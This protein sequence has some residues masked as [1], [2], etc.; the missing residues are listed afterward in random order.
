MDQTMTQPVAV[1]T[2]AASGIGL[3]VTQRLARTHRVALLDINGEA[4]LQAAEQLGSTA[5]ALRCDISD[6][7]SVTAAVQAVFEQFGA[8]DVA[9][10]NAGIGPVGAIR[11][12][13]PAVLAT[14]LDVNLTGNWRFIRACLPHLIGSRGYVIG[15]ASA[16]AIFAPP[17]EGMYAASKAGLEALLNCFRVEVAHLGVGVGIAYPMFIDTPMVRDADREHADFARTRERLP[18]AAGKTFPVSLAADR[19]LRGIQRRQ[20]RVFIP[21]SLHLQYLLRGVLPAMLDRALR[22]IAIDVDQLTEQKVGAR[23]AAA[24]GWS[25]AVLKSQESTGQKTEPRP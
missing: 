19:I 15:V 18:G 4:A 5:M 7:E 12:L 22:P 21:G 6:Q 13:D 17:G 11:H 23:G 8:I 24:G 2:G 9:V 14:V 20:H 10:S 1:V 3:A 16:A 25:A